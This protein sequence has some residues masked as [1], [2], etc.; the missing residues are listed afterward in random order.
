MICEARLIGPWT[1]PAWMESR[2]ESLAVSKYDLAGAVMSESARMSVANFIH[3]I[4]SLQN[5]C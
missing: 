2:C 4:A 1:F 5:I 3:M